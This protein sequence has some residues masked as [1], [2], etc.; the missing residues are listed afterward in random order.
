MNNKARPIFIYLPVRL[1]YQPPANNT[2]LSEQTSHQQPT[3]NTFLRT[4]QHQPS[5]TSQT[6]RLYDFDLY[7]SIWFQILFILSLAFHFCCVWGWAEAP[8]QVP[9]GGDRGRH[10][11]TAMYMRLSR[12]YALGS[13]VLAVPENGG[14][15]SSAAG[16]SGVESI[17]QIQI[18]GCM[19]RTVDPI[20]TYCEVMLCAFV[21]NLNI[22]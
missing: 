16:G 7:P 8:L 4:N 11:F 6:N 18:Y 15:C 5:A 3:S 13:A 2:F 10:S 19:N 22:R 14:W 1:A 9:S 17:K 20:R 12:L 21:M